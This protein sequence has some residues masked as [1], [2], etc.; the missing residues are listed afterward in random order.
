MQSSRHSLGATFDSIAVDW[1]RLF[2]AHFV[3]G[4]VVAAALW[5]RIGPEYFGGIANRRIG[6]SIVIFTA[7]AWL[8]IVVSW[9]LARKW[10]LGTGAT[11]AYIVCLIVIGLVAAAAYAAVGIP[12]SPVFVISLLTTVVQVI[13]LL[14]CLFHAPRDVL[15]SNKSPE[16][17]REG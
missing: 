11:S 12:R 14:L 1:R 16:R 8:P 10:L 6:V 2:I 13:V 7:L 17:T 5:V 3:V 4:I 15:S 9:L